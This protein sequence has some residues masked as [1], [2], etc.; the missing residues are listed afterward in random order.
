MTE[1]SEFRKEDQWS[2]GRCPRGKEL[3]VVSRNQCTVTSFSCNQIL[4]KYSD[5]IRKISCPLIDCPSCNLMPRENQDLVWKSRFGS[6]VYLP[7]CS[8]NTR[9]KTLSSD[10]RP[11]GWRRPTGSSPSQRLFLWNH[12]ERFV[13]VGP[14]LARSCYT[15]PASICLQSVET[16]VFRSVSG[17]AGHA[18]YTDA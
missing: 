15:M 8:Q 2:S 5:Y 9:S 1:T 6:G 4:A 17:E 13:P 10:V 12:R 16:E 14:A 7:L 3:N 11:P 18:Q